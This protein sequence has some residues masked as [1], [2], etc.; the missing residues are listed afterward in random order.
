MSFISKVELKSQLQ[1]MGIKVEGNYV[2]KSDLE[3]IIASEKTYRIVRFYKDGHPKETIKTGLSFEEAQ[4]HCND[5]E[6]SSSTCEEA[7]N[8]ARTEKMG[9]W[10][11]GFYEE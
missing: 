11:D 5:P 1:K 4:E 7:K 10:F 9:E 8:V 2:K 6:T 3:K